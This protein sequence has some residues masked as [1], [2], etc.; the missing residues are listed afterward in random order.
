MK[1][2]SGAERGCDVG[3]G[4]EGISLVELL[5][6]MLLAVVVL[7]IVGGILI[8]SLR[9]EAQ[10]RDGVESASTVQL[11]TQSIGRGVRNASALEVSAPTADTLLLRTRSIDSDVDGGVWRCNAW[12]VSADGEL[13]W[14]VSD[15]AISASP[16]ESELSGWTL[17][18]SALTPSATQPILEFSGTERSVRIAFSVRN[19]D[20][21]PV[22]VDTTYVSRQPVPA[23]GEVREPCL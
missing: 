8:N 19:G 9:V 6:Y 23:T 20:G 5:I 10:V 1:C 21:T 11:V 17:L 12:H 22:I 15:A 7:T 4:D 2:L 3:R 13:R 14:T 16:T 18:G